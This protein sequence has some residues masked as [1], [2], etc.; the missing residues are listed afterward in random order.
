[1]IQNKRRDRVKQKL[2][3]FITTKPD[4]VAICLNDLFKLKTSPSLDW[5]WGDN[6]VEEHIE[7]IVVAIF[8]K[9]NLPHPLKKM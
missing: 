4:L 8:R 1:M 6:T 2:E 5:I 9:Y 7:D 3:E